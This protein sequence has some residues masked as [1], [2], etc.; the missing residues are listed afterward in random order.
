MHNNDGSINVLNYYYNPDVEEGVTTQKLID[1]GFLTNSSVIGKCDENGEENFVWNSYKAIRDTQLSNKKCGFDYY[2]GAD[3]FNN[4]ILRNKSFKTVT[5]TNMSQTPI[6]NYNS[7]YGN[8]YFK[9]INGE[10]AEPY[11]Y[12]IPENFNTID[13]YMR[14]RNGII[15]S[16]YVPT[17]VINEGDSSSN[18]TI[19]EGTLESAE[20]KRCEIQEISCPLHLYQN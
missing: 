10:I 20:R 9:W 4:H 5:F 12:V 8:A 16:D 14:D 2:C 6:S 11:N 1:D 13:D 7:V 17:L 18:S 15:V 19:G 3:I